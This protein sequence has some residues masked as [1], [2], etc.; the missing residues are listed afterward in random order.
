MS[1]QDEEHELNR[2]IHKEYAHI[3]SLCRE[4]RNKLADSMPTLK[5]EQESGGAGW[6]KFLNTSTGNYAK[7][8]VVLKKKDEIEIWFK[9]GAVVPTDE[10][11]AEKPVRSAMHRKSSKGFHISCASHIDDDVIAWCREAG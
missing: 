11:V 2:Y 6:I 8:G 10:D 4:L 9:S 7:F 3:E 1:Y 5:A